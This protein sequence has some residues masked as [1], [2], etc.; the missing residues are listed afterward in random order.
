MYS[1]MKPA[2]LHARFVLALALL[3]PVYFAVSA[4]GT[5]FGLWDWRTG[6]GLLTIRI[7]PV[8]LGLVALLALISLVTTIRRKPRA[9]WLAALVAFAIPLAIIGS[10]ASLRSKAA[11]IPAI[12]DVATD[13]SD[14]PQ[15]SNARLAARKTAQAN[16][17]NDYAAPLGTLAPW[18]DAEQSLA[19]RSHADIIAAS[20][21]QLKPIPLK[22][23]NRAQALAAVSAA[24]DAMGFTDIAI[25]AE[26]GRVEGVAQTFWFGFKDDVV[27]RVSEDRIDFRSVSRVG[28]SDLG[29]NAARIAELRRGVASRIA[30]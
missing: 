30:P 10:L 11:A 17:L 6:L 23:T 26:A 9:G 5:R 4:L 19:P 2:P 12:H 14:P 27:A 22:A 25:D 21:P 16:K 24:M 7:G 29:A 28:L 15:F 20:Y 8:I 18:H 1:A 13:T 3:L